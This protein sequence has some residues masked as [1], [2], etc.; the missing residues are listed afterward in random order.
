MLAGS[1][2]EE[3][4]FMVAVLEKYLFS[5]YLCDL[6]WLLACRDPKSSI[7]CGSTVRSN[8][9]LR[10]LESGNAEHQVP[11][12]IRSIYGASLCWRHHLHQLFHES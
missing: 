6:K 1:W 2:K 11:S 9:S 3:A 12:P 7:G 5:I 8:C 10:I 4:V